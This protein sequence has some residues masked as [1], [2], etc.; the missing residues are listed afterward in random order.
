MNEMSRRP[1]LRAVARQVTTGPVNAYNCPGQSKTQ[2]DLDLFLRTLPSTMKKATDCLIQ[3]LMSDA[4]L[5]RGAK[6]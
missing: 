4:L 1:S 6:P 5:A 3:E 2:S